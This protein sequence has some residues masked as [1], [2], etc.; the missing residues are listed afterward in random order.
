[1]RGG[2]C[3]RHPS[4]PSAF[5]CERCGDFRCEGCRRTVELRDLCPPCHA[6]EARDASASLWAI[7]AAIFGFWGL[8]CA[9][10]GWLGVLLGVIALVLC[11]RSG[12]RAGRVLA[13]IG[14]SLGVIGTVLFVLAMTNA[15][16]NPDAFEPEPGE[17]ELWAP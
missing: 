16:M 11:V 9:P 3:K 13:A 17:E 5:T 14:V 4:M 1:M 12:K 8:G 2:P 10:V 15:I 6:I 7:F